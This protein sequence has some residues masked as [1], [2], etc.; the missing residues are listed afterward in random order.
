M[1]DPP[2]PPDT[3]PPDVNSEKTLIQRAKPRY[4]SHTD[5]DVVAEYSHSTKIV[6]DGRDYHY[7][8]ALGDRVRRFETESRAKLYADI[9]ELTG[10]FREEKTGDRGVPPPVARACDRNLLMA[11]HVATPNMGVQWTARS[12]EMDESEVRNAVDL[13]R[14]RAKGARQDPHFHDTE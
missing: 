11:Y 2:Y 13:I 10:G 7:V 5:P 3:P 9:Q 4:M 8:N 12:Y 14:D 6:R 1:S